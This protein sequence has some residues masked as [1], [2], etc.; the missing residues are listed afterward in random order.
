[1]GCTELTESSASPAASL[2]GN[3]SFSRGDSSN[4]FLKSS[5]PAALILSCC[6]LGCSLPVTNDHLHRKAVNS[7]HQETLLWSYMPAR[8]SGSAGRL[9]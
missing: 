6:P 9:R 8:V 4:M 3:S 7:S 2:K 5:T 1:M